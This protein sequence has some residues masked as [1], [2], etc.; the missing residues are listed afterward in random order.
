MGKALRFTGEQQDAS[1]DH[2]ISG[3]DRT[4]GGVL[5][6]VTSAAQLITDADATYERE[7][8][9]LRAMSLAAAHASRG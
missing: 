4:A 8:Q 9:G 7:A 2:L 5:H 1:P 6:A 3:G